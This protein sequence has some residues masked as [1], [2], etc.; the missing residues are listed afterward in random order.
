MSSSS[1]SSSPW[2]ATIVVLPETAKGTHGDGSFRA[3]L[4]IDAARAVVEARA[5]SGLGWTLPS[6]AAVEVRC[7]ECGAGAGVCSFCA[8][9]KIWTLP[10]KGH[11]STTEK[12]SGMEVIKLG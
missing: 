2:D 12:A 11:I 7:R 9:V 10:W 6:L 3:L 5:A 8:G 4:P 1:M